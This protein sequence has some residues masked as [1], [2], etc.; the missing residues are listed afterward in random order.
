[1]LH[2]VA[3]FL[4]I[5]GVGFSI[6]P[7]NRIDDHLGSVIPEL[8]NKFPHNLDLFRRSQEPA[9]NALKTEIQLF[10]FLHKPRH[11]IRKIIIIIRWKTRMVGKYGSWQQTGLYSHMG[12]HGKGYCR[13]TPSKTR[14]IID[15]SY[16]FLFIVRHCFH[17][18]IF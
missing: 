3:H 6:F 7:H 11:L 9:G 12:N 1:M 4:C 17:S 18:Y 16:F 13:R 5:G 10:P 14:Y 2:F 15:D 8:T